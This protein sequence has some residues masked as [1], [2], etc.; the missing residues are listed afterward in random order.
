M[1]LKLFVSLILSVFLL[2]ACSKSKSL[3]HAVRSS[4]SNSIINGEDVKATDL[5]AKHTVALGPAKG[6]QICS[7]V[8]IAPH[9]ILTAGHC[10]QGI[11][12]G[13]IYFGLVAK[14]KTATAIYQITKVTL[15]PRYCRSCLMNDG[16][17][18]NGNDL[19]IVEFDKDLPEGFEPVEFANFDQVKTDAT[20][21]LAGYGATEKQEYD[22]L[23][24]TNVLIKQTDDSEFK[25]Q[26]TKSGSCDGDS[27]GP[28]FFQEG[29]KLT[30]AGI[31]SR[32]DEECHKHGI[33][34]IPAA[35]ADWIKEVT[36]DPAAS[37]EQ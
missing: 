35:H 29:D 5:Y 14:P 25:T 22:V 8:I 21:Y 24:V 2:S 10:A 1:S 20:V 34:T 32:G 28:A 9:F 19:S 31:T 23:K 18:S 27:G 30:L 4:D 12:K 3:T 15:H 11:K 16:M 36:F 17:L 6:D 13:K 33:Y 7:G 26:E 37:D